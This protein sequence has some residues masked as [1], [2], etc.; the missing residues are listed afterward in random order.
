MRIIYR[1]TEDWFKQ[2]VNR[3]RHRC[4]VASPYV[5]GILAAYLSRLEDRAQITLLTRV[6]IQEFA[7]GACDIEVLERIA[8]FG[9][10][11]LSEPR[12]HAKVYVVDDTALVTSANAT[13]GGFEGNYECGIETTDPK[14][15]EELVN[16]IERGFRKRGTPRLWSDTDLFGLEQPIYALAKLLDDG[17]AHIYEDPLGE[18]VCIRDAAERNHW[19]MKFFYWTRVALLGIL[20]L[21]DEFTLEELQTICFDK[22]VEEFPCKRAWKAKLHKELTVLRDIGIV[23]IAR[24]G[25]YRRLVG[26][27]E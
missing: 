27:T 17:L 2:H 1:P 5:T 20:R 26:K 9:A 21:G 12:L 3:C 15:V 23:E 18:Y 22:F 4:L 19:A 25:R 11:I 8:S 14:Q 7:L 10:R 24:P 16:A 13:L 6:R